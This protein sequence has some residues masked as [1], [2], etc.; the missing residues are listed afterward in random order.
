M[1]S[2]YLLTLLAFIA[3]CLPFKLLYGFVAVAVLFF[4]YCHSC[5][6]YF[7][8]F[9]A[10]AIFV[11]FMDYCQIILDK[12]LIFLQWFLDGVAC[13][14]TFILHCICI[15]LL[16]YLYSYI[17]MW[18]YLLYDYIFMCIYFHYYYIIFL[19][20]FVSCCWWQTYL[21]LIAQVFLITFNFVV[22]F[23]FSALP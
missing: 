12:S 20:Y 11:W 18:Q 9:F 2:V 14:L 16:L 5:W 10:A 6:W 7:F 21:V 17:H 15:I 23:I 19:V 22:V 3:V 4:F 1:Q 13:E 8:F